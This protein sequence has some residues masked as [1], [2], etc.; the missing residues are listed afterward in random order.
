MTVRTQKTSEGLRVE[1]TAE[2]KPIV[3]EITKFKMMWMQNW[4]PFLIISFFF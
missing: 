4:T 1:I 3:F 2:S